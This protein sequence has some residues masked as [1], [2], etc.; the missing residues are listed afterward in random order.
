MPSIRDI[1][2]ATG[3]SVATVSRA[4]RGDPKVKKHTSGLVLKAAATLGY[5]HNPHIGQLMSAIR[6]RSNS[7]FH[8]NLALV[9][10]TDREEWKSDVPL[11]H[12]RDGI[13]T[14]AAEIGFSV[15]EF[16]FA[17]QPV[18]KLRRVL[19]SRGINGVIISVPSSIV[20]GFDVEMDLSGFSCVALGSGLN[21]PQLERA[22]FDTYNGMRLALAATG[23]KFGKGVAALWDFASDAA[24]HHTAKASFLVHHPGGPAL[25]AK[26]FLD[27]HS[28]HQEETLELLHRHS[29][30]SLLLFPRFQ[31]PQWI[32]RQ[33]PAKNL[34]WFNRP[35]RRTCFGWV[36]H[37][38][39]LLGKWVVDLVSAKISLNETGVPDNHH[40]VFIP[41]KWQKG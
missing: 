27:I 23:E 15:S 10:P 38:N 33:I 13:F 29:I 26:L 1:A 35:P 17:S 4:L 16:N 6:R 2:D 40:V 31:P 21:S 9:W 25:A 30:R 22:L 12:M 11:K 39:R 36:D 7:S 20:G 32:L 41:P 3:V 19:I 14:R 5:R 24:T 18:A 8:G 34:V 37:G 28:L